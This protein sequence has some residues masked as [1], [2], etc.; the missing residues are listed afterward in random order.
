MKL[1]YV[2]R[3]RNLLENYNMRNTKIKK[4]LLIAYSL[5]RSLQVMKHL[6]ESQ[7]IG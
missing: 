5:P 4:T 7:Y 3:Q 2:G 6:Y 1:I